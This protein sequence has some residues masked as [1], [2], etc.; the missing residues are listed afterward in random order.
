MLLRGGNQQNKNNNKNNNNNNNNNNKNNNVDNKQINID[1]DQTE[2]DAANADLVFIIL[3]DYNKTI[4]LIFRSNAGTSVECR[5][6]KCGDTV[7]NARRTTLTRRIDYKCC[8]SSSSL[9]PFFFLKK[10]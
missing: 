5:V 8:L 2:N 6:R 4:Y 7:V 1:N 3:F 10:N 9:Y